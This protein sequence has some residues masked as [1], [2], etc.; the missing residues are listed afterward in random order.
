[1]AGGVFISYRRDNAGYASKLLADRLTAR[2]GRKQVFLD[3]VN[4]EYGDDF[5][6]EITT[7]IE[8]CRVLLAVIDP[9]WVAALNER[10]SA[11]RKD[12]VRLEIELA[13]RRGLRVIPVLVDPAHLNSLRASAGWR[14][15]TPFS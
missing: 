15:P 8:S 12:Y 5:V 10:I 14:P 11:Q 9:H 1:M 6:E 3:V 4:I 7:A 13:L 2:Y